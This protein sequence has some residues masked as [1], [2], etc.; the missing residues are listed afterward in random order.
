MPVRIANKAGNDTSVRLL[1]RPE[2][3]DRHNPEIE[4]DPDFF[5]VLADA[6]GLLRYGL[7][8][9]DQSGDA[10]ARLRVA[11][12]VA[13]LVVRGCSHLLESLCGIVW[14]RIEGSEELALQRIGCG[15]GP[16][17]AGRPA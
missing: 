16:D 6:L 1:M 15:V 7:Q 12:A 11:P 5:Q 17:H 14:V 13:R 9:D 8:V 10:P 2:A 4:V 3:V